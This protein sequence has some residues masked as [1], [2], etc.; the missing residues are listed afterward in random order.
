MKKRIRLSM[1]ACAVAPFAVA[2]AS[3]AADC[4]FEKRIH[5]LS[6]ALADAPN[7]DRRARA[8]AKYAELVH[9]M[10]QL[11]LY[12]QFSICSD[13]DGGASIDFQTPEQTLR[14]SVM[15]LSDW[16]GWYNSK[17]ESLGVSVAD[18]AADAAQRGLDK[19]SSAQSQ[20]SER[21]DARLIHSGSFDEI[22]AIYNELRGARQQSMDNLTRMSD[23]YLCSA[24]TAEELELAKLYHDVIPNSAMCN[25]LERQALLDRIQRA[26]MI[27][28]GALLDAATF[29]RVRDLCPRPP[30]IAESSTKKTV[31]AGSQHKSQISRIGYRKTDDL[32][33]EI[34]EALKK[35][36][37]SPNDTGWS[38]MIVRNIMT[39]R[40]KKGKI[41][42]RSDYFGFKTT[43]HEDVVKEW[44][45]IKQ[46][47]TRYTKDDRTC[48]TTRVLFITNMSRAQCDEFYRLANEGLARMSG[49]SRSNLGWP[50]PLNGVVDP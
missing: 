2:L 22:L 18:S 40:D 50:G 23:R 33:A 21:G 28:F 49:T 39:T 42:Q 48:E 38:G 19:L 20:L 14:D 13:Q 34:D 7:A 44:E 12:T 1:F 16:I 6:T 37:P 5:E 27:G 41:T 15:R 8:S 26:P 43:R 31:A 46:F 3:A 11:D 35:V 10:H 9:E 45:R 30:S 47:D 29:Q 17:A 4:P 32:L 25:D 36:K 24:L